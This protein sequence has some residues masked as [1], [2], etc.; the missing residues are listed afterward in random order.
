M[1][2]FE[3][4]LNNLRNEVKGDVKTNEAVEKWLKDYELRK[5]NGLGDVPIPMRIRAYPKEMEDRIKYALSL[6]KDED[7]ILPK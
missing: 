5:K 1:D 6:F 7:S 3:I 4:W 2:I